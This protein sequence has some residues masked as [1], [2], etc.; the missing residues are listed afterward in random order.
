[1]PVIRRS[2]GSVRTDDMNDESSTCMLG[3]E[4]DA[5]SHGFNATAQSL[6][7]ETKKQTAHLAARKK[8]SYTYQSALEKRLTSI[9]QKRQ[10][11][12]DIRRGRFSKA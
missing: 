9:A 1:M 8:S 2:L 3:V 6:P 4:E 10:P 7:T 12:K 5:S 11:G